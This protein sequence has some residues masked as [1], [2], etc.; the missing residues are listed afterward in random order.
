[1]EE[2]RS[3][4]LQRWLAVKRPAFLFISGLLIPSVFQSLK[5]SAHFFTQLSKVL[6]LS[7]VQEVS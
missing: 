4:V 3:S 5:P 2:R 7:K 6:K 1:M